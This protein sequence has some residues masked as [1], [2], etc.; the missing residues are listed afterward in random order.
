VAAANFS[1]VKGHWSTQ[2]ESVEIQV[3]WTARLKG[4]CLTCWARAPTEKAA[5]PD[6][7]VPSF[8]DSLKAVQDVTCLVDIFPIP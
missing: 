6:I 4:E 3:I 2:T 1:L 7:L 8:L 5:Q